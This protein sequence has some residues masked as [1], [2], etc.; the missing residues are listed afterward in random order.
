MRLFCHEFG[1]SSAPRGLWLH[2]FMGT[3]E[4]GK[5]LQA[6]LGPRFRLLSPDLP[7]HG[8][9]PAADW[10][11]G[12]TLEALAE[13]A[14]GC[15]WAGGY[16]M[17][18]RLLM[19]AA[20]KHPG[21]FRH[22]VIESASLGY[23]SPEE[24]A[25]RRGL[26]RQ[27]GDELIATGLSA[28]RENWYRMEMWAGWSPSSPAAGDEHELAAALQLFS[29]GNQPDLRQWLSTT[30]CRVLWLAGCRDPVY[31]Q[32]A[33]WVERHTR[34]TPVLTDAGHNPH[35]QQPEA[36]AGAVRAFLSP[37]SHSHLQAQDQ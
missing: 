25:R 21:A 32:Q 19:M 9:T 16:S 33:R 6:R 10:A 1:N 35:R 8:R 3:G 17:G 4:H 27:R 34:H 37:P 20:A 23:A 24:R 28:F 18:G 15:A 13:L 29:T 22:L 5:D 7:G 26:D 12:S 2:G 31:A 36:W 11:L 30:T 14:A